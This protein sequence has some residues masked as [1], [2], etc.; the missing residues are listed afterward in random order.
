MRNRLLLTLLS[1]ALVA[2]AC[3]EGA[4]TTSET[5]TLRYSY[6]PGD[7]LT[8]ALTQQMT[9]AMTMTG[10]GDIGVPGTLDMNM[11]MD[12]VSRLEYEIEEGPDPETIRITIGMTIV[13]GSGTMD[14][15]GRIEEMSFDDLF[16]GVGPMEIEM[17]LDAQGNV[18]EILV[19]GHQL[20]P[21][22]FGDLGSTPAFGVGSPEH[23]GPQFPDGPIEV[24]RTWE[25]EVVNAA[26][27]IETRVVGEHRI[28]GTEL[29]AGRDTYRIETITTTD[30]IVIVFEDL[31]DLIAENAAV[32]GQEASAAEMASAMEELEI[33]DIEMNYRIDG[34]TIEMTSWFDADEGVLVRAEWS[35]PMTMSMEMKNL[36]DGSDMEMSF[37]T[38]M[39][40]TMQLTD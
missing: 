21:G 23:I 22:L 19:G 24:G 26:F 28:T 35:G 31:V 13:E 6:Q 1:F 17:I 2:A 4:G 29:V 8:Y 30:P 37:D 9:M 20:P 40:Q 38:M 15:M 34:F 18:I 16:S 32:F 5:I 10:A 27:G 36:P 12:M 25:T 39:T 11:D 14:T 33:L 7:S 3:G